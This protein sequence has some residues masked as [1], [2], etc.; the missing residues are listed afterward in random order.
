[1]SAPKKCFKA[2]CV[3]LC[4]VFVIVAVMEKIK[5]KDTL[6]AS[7]IFHKVLEEQRCAPVGKL[8]P[9]VWRSGNC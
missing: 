5:K 9:Q 4:A 2:P 1:M 8:L 7:V 6:K 3:F